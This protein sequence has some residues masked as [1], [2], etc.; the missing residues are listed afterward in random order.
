MIPA[1]LL[2]TLFHQIMYVPVLPA[3][4][5]IDPAIFIPQNG[6]QGLGSANQSSHP[7]QSVSAH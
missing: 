5:N 2:S 6:S 3:K 1:T 7:E 4:P